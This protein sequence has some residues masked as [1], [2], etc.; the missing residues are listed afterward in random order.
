MRP[1]AEYR[2]PDAFFLELKNEGVIC[3]SPTDGEG[4]VV[5]PGYDDGGVISI[6]EG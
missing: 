1:M 4:T 5:I 3:D 6:T 2:K